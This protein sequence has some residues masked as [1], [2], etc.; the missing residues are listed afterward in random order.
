MCRVMVMTSAQRFELMRL[1]ERHP[2]TP[3]HVDPLWMLKRLRP[4]QFVDL[5]AAL[6]IDVAPLLGP[7]WMRAGPGAARPSIKPMEKKEAAARAPST[8]D[9]RRGSLR[10]VVGDQRVVERTPMRGIAG[11]RDPGKHRSHERWSPRQPAHHGRL[12]NPAM[13]EIAVI[14]PPQLHHALGHDPEYPSAQPRRAGQSGAPT[15]SVFR[16]RR[17]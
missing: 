11:L 9:A 15:P 5:A 16:S 4:A 10:L 2:A 17:K 14:N 6:G 12:T 3:E 7:E 8:S 1:L 13:P